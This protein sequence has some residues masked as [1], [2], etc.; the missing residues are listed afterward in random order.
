MADEPFPTL[1]N[2]RRYINAFM[3]VTTS[4][5]TPY[6][7]SE[8]DIKTLTNDKFEQF[9]SPWFG[10]LMSAEQAT[11]QLEQFLLPGTPL[12]KP[13]I[14]ARERLQGML[15]WESS[16]WGPDLVVKT[17]HDFDKL[18]FNRKL[19]G[20]IQIKWA[21]DE[22]LLRYNANLLGQS[23]QDGQSWRWGHCL[24][25]LNADRL[26]LVPSDFRSIREGEASVS[27]FRFLWSV[28]LHEFC[29]AYL[30]V[31]TGHN[32]FDHDDSKTGH[33]GHHGQHF[34]RCIYAVDRSTRGLLG[35]GALCSF[36]GQDGKPINVF[37][38]ENHTVEP[39]PSRW[40]ELKG[41]GY[42]M[43]VQACGHGV[44]RLILRGS[45]MFQHLVLLD[46]A[47]QRRVYSL[48]IGKTTITEEI[49]LSR[50]SFMKTR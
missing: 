40:A 42:R 32:D 2:R 35:I 46:L 43:V 18:F 44:R 7:C 25:D 13:Q 30:Q 33:D 27:Q 21:S 45:G 41:K 24:I 20:H 28:V 3:K 31:L 34:Q 26:L 14:K 17:A 48:R 36:T 12:T 4:T 10:K 47:K 23:N 49:S 29:H 22:Q 1:P 11:V 6:P 16:D 15:R 50:T 9:D 5:G 39:K 38:V 19:K 8:D 37:D